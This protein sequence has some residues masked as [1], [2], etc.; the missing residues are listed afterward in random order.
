[1]ARHSN[2]KDSNF[3]R[4]IAILLTLIL[5]C[6]IIL[7]IK[8]KLTEHKENEIQREISQVLDTIDIPQD[9]ITPEKTERQL[10]IEE[11]QK[12]NEDIIGWL[13]IEGTNINYPVLQGVDND[14]YLKHTYRHEK[15]SSGSIF[16]D[17]DYDF[18]TPSN[19]LLIYGHRNK[20]GLMFEDLINYKK[21]A[22][23]NEHKQIRFTT[24]TE[25][26]TFEIISA[27]NSRVYYQDETNVFRYYQFVNAKN[28]KEY[29]SYI[30][31]SKKASLYDTGKTAEY[32]E[33]LLTLSTCDYSQKNGRFAVVAKE[34]K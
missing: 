11:L 25:D 3:K 31:N 17:K 33:R 15:I 26:M 24:P 9:K 2:K 6:S 30:N 34:V 21:E 13:E 32:G 12:E 4:T 19:N 20:K 1:M 8:I 22:Y 27:F 7:I 28:Q 10:Q 14:Y 16:L 5:I 23:Y 29:E 18:N